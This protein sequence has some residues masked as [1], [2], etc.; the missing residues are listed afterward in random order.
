MTKKDLV[1]DMATRI[2]RRFEA[3]KDRWVNVTKQV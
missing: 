2:S 1:G 3:N